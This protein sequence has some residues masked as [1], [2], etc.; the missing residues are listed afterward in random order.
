M[1]LKNSKIQPNTDIYQ[2]VLHNGSLRNMLQI[3]DMTNDNKFI[4]KISK[5][6]FKINLSPKIEEV[7]GYNNDNINI[8]IYNCIPSVLVSYINKNKNDYNRI[9]QLRNIRKIPVQTI[10]KVIVW[11][12]NIFI[13]ITINE[14]IIHFSISDEP[15]ISPNVPI[16]FKY[17]LS[18]EPEF[19]TRNYNNCYI[20]MMDLYNSTEITKVKLPQEVCLFYH[21]LIKMLHKILNK[22]YYPFIQ[23][24][25][26][27]GDNFMLWSNPLYGFNCI[28]KIFI[29]LNF[30]KD[31]YTICDSILLQYNTYIRCGISFGDCCGGIWDGK[32]FRI[33]G[34]IIN[35]AS[36]LE[37]ACEKNSINLSQE[38]INT[39]EL[40]MLENVDTKRTFLK[41]F[42]YKNIYTVNT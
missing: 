37:T 38:C 19:H 8:Y 18:Y 30:V 6:D 31:F 12:E 28:N 9:T 17:K 7:F 10:S 14:Y 4:I 25:E 15:L 11:I 32:T 40:Q 5:C 24:I 1:G 41:G 21:N 26:C 13:D 23:L 20:I 29:I 34:S 2:Y 33:S 16:D 42:G 3:H 22:K 39:E 36:R 35:L 27:V